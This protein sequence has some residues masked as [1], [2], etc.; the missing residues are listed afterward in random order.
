[1]LQNYFSH[2]PWLQIIV[3][4]VAYFAIGAIWYMPAVF[5]NAWAAG[6]KLDR[7]NSEEMKKTL[8][9]LMAITFVLTFLIAVGMGLLLYVLQAPGTCMSGIKAGLMVSGI[10][11]VLPMGINYAYTGKSIKLLCIDGGYH[12]IGI[13]LMG[14]IMSV[15]K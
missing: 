6:H 8:P 15:W 13:T 2:A 14:I 7:S 3:S 1:M 12:V 5:G 11:C 9:K 4:A 10:F